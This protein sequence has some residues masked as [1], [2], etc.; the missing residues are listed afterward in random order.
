M[1]RIPGDWFGLNEEG[2]ILTGTRTGAT[3]RLGDPLRVRVHR[4][5]P[6]RGRVDLDVSGEGPAG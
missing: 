1:R 4:V 5:D 3:V 2:T 6:V